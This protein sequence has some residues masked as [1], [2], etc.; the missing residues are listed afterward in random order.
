LLVKKVRL[1]IGAIGAVGAAPALGL[2]MPAGNAA[3]AAAPAPAHAGKTVALQDRAA[4]SFGCA[5]A[6]SGS[7]NGLHAVM[8]F[9]GGRVCGQSASIGVAK[10]GLLER[11]RYWS[12]D[13]LL[14]TRYLHGSL[15]AGTFFH[16]S[17]GRSW[18]TE[19]CMAVV[20][21]NTLAVEYGVVCE[22]TSG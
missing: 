11:V 4:S 5:Y 17:T 3:A 15:G 8:G 21:E 22:P 19:V 20:N 9:S 6:D 16:S 1:A 2:M 10:S 14:S 12:G 13:D 7:V 18:A